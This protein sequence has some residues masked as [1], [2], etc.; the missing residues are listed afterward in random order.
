MIVGAEDFGWGN[1]VGV[2]SMER[3]IGLE[4]HCQDVA[5][6]AHIYSS[7]YCPV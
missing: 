4:M 6:R 1:F 3:I 5:L 7:H 2:F